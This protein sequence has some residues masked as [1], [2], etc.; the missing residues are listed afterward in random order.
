MNQSTPHI[1][2]FASQRFS[3]YV[4]RY[5]FY[6]FDEQATLNL[7]PEGS[8]ELIFQLHGDFE[9]R[10]VIG[11]EWNIR[12]QNF[13]GGLHSKS[14]EVRSVKEQSRILSVKFN[15]LGARHFIQDKLNLFKNQVIDLSEVLETQANQHLESVSDMEMVHSLESFLVKNFNKKDAGIIDHAVEILTASHGFISI[16]ELTQRLNISPSHFRLRF[17]EQIGMSP[18]EYSKILRIK[19]ITN[20]L[21]SNPSVRL[22][23][24]AHRLGYFDQAHFI[25]DFQSVTNSSPKEYINRLQK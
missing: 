6:D 21:K 13:I 12:P 15:P 14:F 17:N 5:R 16:K 1:N 25:K 11:D 4:D 19:Y 2:D 8:I 9:Q 23:E 10:S 3:K 7:D 20:Y 22:T 18:K 24:F